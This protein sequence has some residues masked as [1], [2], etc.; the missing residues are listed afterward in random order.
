MKKKT[1]ILVI[2]GYFLP[3]SGIR[4]RNSAS[5]LFALFIETANDCLMSFVNKV[6]SGS[7]FSFEF[8]VFQRNEIINSCIKISRDG[9]VLAISAISHKHC[10]QEDIKTRSHKSNGRTE[11][12]KR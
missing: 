12:S 7:A 2:V 10:K 3:A 11:R 9:F 5:I 6:E 1:N 8:F 4:R